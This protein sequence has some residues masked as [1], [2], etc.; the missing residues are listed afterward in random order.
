MVDDIV[1]RKLLEIVPEENIMVAEPMKKHTS[2]RIGGEA[3]FLVTVTEIEEIKKILELVRR[4]NI[5]LTILGNGTNILVKDGG[6]RGITLKLE[7]RKMTKQIEEDTIIYTCGSSLPVA[8]IA[9]RAL[10]DEVTGLE[11][12]AGIP[13]TLGGAI[14]MNA[15]AFGGQMQ[16]IVL[17]TTYIDTDG[18]CYQINQ[19]EHEFEYRNSIFSKIPAII[20]ESKLI[21]KKGNKQEIVAKM[22]E[23]KQERIEKQPTEFASAGSTFKRG[24]GF[25]TA[26]VIDECGLKGY[27][28]GDAQISEKHAGFIVNKGEAT[29]KEVL[30]LIQYIKQEVKKK[31][32]YELEEEIQIIGE[33][34]IGG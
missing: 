34:K 10:E 27:Q 31:T 9:N 20:L 7:F 15:G 2:F 4:K 5:P 29:A 21:L 33:E 11:F 23:N 22:K 16:D 24:N 19:E 30:E 28:I 8:V 1:Y 18:D 6:I 13:G 26:K 14:R 3:D 12:A 17:E 32:G 25:I